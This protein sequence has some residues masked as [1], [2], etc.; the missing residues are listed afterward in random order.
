[1]SPLLRVSVSQVIREPENT[2]ASCFFQEKAIQHY[3]SGAGR[4]AADW[5][6]G[7]LR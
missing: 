1:M 2:N 3:F 4:L 6:G 5:E 7:E